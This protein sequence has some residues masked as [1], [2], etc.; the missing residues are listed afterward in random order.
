[1][2]LKLPISFVFYF[3]FPPVVNSGPD[4]WNNTLIGPS[5]RT[6]MD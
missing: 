2:V 6:C 4:A 3:F 5:R 1:M